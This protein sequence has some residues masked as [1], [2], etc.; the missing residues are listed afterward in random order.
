TNAVAASTGT[1]ALT[2]STDSVTLRSPSQQIDAMAYTSGQPD[3]VS[4]N[5]SPDGDVAG[6]FALHTTLSSKPSSP[7]T[8]V[9]GAAF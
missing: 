9:T 5:R 1:L 8:R 3:G 2:N 6:A 7:G 4:L